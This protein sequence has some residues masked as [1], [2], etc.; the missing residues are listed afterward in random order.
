MKPIVLF[1]GLIFAAACSLISAQ[2][3]AWK[4]PDISD[5]PCNAP[6]AITYPAPLINALMALPQGFRVYLPLGNAAYYRWIYQKVHAGTPATDPAQLLLLKPRV[7]FPSLV[8]LLGLADGTVDVYGLL[9][10]AGRWYQVRAIPTNAVATVLLASIVNASPGAAPFGFGGTVLPT[11][12]VWADS[13][14]TVEWHCF[15]G[16]VQVFNVLSSTPALTPQQI[17]DISAVLQPYGFKSQNFM[18]MPY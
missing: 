2:P 17:S 12:Y 18:T 14:T 7:R 13:T 6:P 10:P 3:L 9:P 11:R 5:G 1:A 15:E 8:A 16:D 4:D